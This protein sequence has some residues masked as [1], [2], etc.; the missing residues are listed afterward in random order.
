[1]G[2]TTIIDKD[3][4]WK[5]LYN[6]VKSLNG[7]VEVTVGVLGNTETGGLHQKDAA[8]KSQP[9]TVVEIAAVQEFGTRDGRIPSRPVIR[10]TFDRLRE[11]LQQD[12]NKLVLKVLFEGLNPVKAMSMI[13]LKL[14]SEMKKTIT[15]GAGIPPPNAQ[16]TIDA[17]GSARP[18]VDTGRLLNSYSYVVTVDGQEQQIQKPR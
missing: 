4:G 2:R 12:I 9:L 10:G 15:Q 14:S 7:S 8:G 18:L 5:A 6:R 13:G 16:S 17:K 11:E 1:M 3:S